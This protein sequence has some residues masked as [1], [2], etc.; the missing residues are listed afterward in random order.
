[1]VWNGEVSL[2]YAAAVV[3]VICSMFSISD[4]QSVKTGEIFEIFLTSL[5][6]R[7]LAKPVARW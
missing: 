5:I 2:G 4:R 3:P 7:V 1:M 6:S